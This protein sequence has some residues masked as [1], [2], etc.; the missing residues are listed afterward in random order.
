MFCHFHV[1]VFPLS[2]CTLTIGGRCVH[3]RIVDD[4]IAGLLQIGQPFEMS[5]GRSVLLFGRSKPSHACNIRLL[6]LR[7]KIIEVAVFLVEPAEPKVSP[8]HAVALER[9]GWA[10]F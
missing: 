8:A 3:E 5:V 1:I 7:D 10:L 9:V 6:S 4:I 2:I